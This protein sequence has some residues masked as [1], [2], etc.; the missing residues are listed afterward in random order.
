MKS[1]IIKCEVCLC[2]GRGADSGYGKSGFNT[3]GTGRATFFKDFSDKYKGMHYL[4]YEKEIAGKKS[5]YIGL[6]GE[7]G[8]IIIAGTSYNPSSVAIPTDH[9][10]FK[11]VTRLTHNHPADS[12]RVLG[13]SFSRADVINNSALNLNSTRAVANEK[14]YIIQKSKTFKKSDANRMMRLASTSDSKWNEGANKLLSKVNKNGT[15]SHKSVQTISLGYGTR[16]WKN[17]TKN[18]G[19]DYIEKKNK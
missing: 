9:P 4:D 16:I 14:T 7:D 17:L 3:G 6:Y 10:D 11:K 8:K 18:S 15:L 13:G 1:K 19:Y 5:E 12:H 2:G